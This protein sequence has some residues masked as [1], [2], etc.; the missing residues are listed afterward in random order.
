MR[1]LLLPQVLLFSLCCNFLRS[2]CEAFRS[3]LIS[4][5]V[6]SRKQKATTTTTTTTIMTMPMTKKNSDDEQQ[7]NNNNQSRNR[8]HLF[9][10][11]TITAFVTL[12]ESDFDDGVGAKSSLESK[13]KE[14]AGALQ[15]VREQLEDNNNNYEVQTVRIATNPFPE[16]LLGNNNGDSSRKNII[17]DQIVQKRLKLL[18]D[19]LEKYG[20]TFFSLGPACSEETVQV[21]TQIVDFSTKFSCS[22]QLPSCDVA[23]AKAS[24]ETVLR[25]SKLG[26]PED[27]GLANF[28][29]CVANVKAYC[30]FFPAAKAKD[31]ND[32]DTFKIRFAIGLEN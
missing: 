23:L 3:N 26:N 12:E 1:I 27:G 11:R 19:C 17:D 22:V 5:A 6:R 14:T 16:Y 7:E 29:F 4:A 9:K 32:G 31:E 8:N 18:D 2:S 15:T 28:R 13:I 21:C 24:A 20:I 25:N 30:P 10:V